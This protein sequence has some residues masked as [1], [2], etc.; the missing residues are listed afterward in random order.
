M[1]LAYTLQICNKLLRHEWMWVLGN[2]S[3][4]FVIW[5]MF[6]HVRVLGN[7]ICV[8]LYTYMYTHCNNLLKRKIECNHIVFFSC[9]KILLVYISCG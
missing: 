1:L 2:I 8:C 4:L 3:F 7:V 5:K 6:N 9:L